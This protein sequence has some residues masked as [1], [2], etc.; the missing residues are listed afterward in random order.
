MS[1]HHIAKPFVVRSPLSVYIYNMPEMKEISLLIE[2]KNKKPL[3]LMDLTKSFVALA[4]QFNSYVSENGDSKVTREAK[5]FVKE[6]RTGSIIMELYEIATIGVL[7][8][9][10]NVNTIVGFAGYIKD[11]YNFLLGKS[12]EKPTE[13]T[14]ND[15]RE[16]SQIVNPVANDNASQI[17]ISATINNHIE[18]QFNISSLEANAV[19]NVIDKAIKELKVPELANDIKTKVLLKWWQTRTDVKAKAGNKGVIDELSDKPMNITF[20]DENLNE[21]MLHKDY[22]PN[23][24]VYVVDV[25]LQTVSGKLVAYKVVKLHETFEIEDDRK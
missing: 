23:E 9:V 13:F 25:K 6:I 21:E 7:P 5:L 2:I 15:Y 20:E 24:T 17:N 19:Q 1:C 12:D 14:S 4:S 8:F 22:N 11:A 18:N 16:L 10:E 3:E